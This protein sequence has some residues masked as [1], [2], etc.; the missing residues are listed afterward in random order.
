MNTLSHNKRINKVTVHA[1][2]RHS[3]IAV[4]AMLKC[5]GTSVWRTRTFKL[6]L[7]SPLDDMGWG[8][9]TE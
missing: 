4:A 8:V 5:F 1:P 6:L 2:L 9:N 3:E 7:C